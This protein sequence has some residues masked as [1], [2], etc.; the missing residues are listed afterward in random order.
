MLRRALPRSYLV[1]ALTVLNNYSSVWLQA[2]DRNVS[3][4]VASRAVGACGVNGASGEGSG[5]KGGD[6]ELHVCGDV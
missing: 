4:R 1:A 6:A 2:N 3:Y 5:E